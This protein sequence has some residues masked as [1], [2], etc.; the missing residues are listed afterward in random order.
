MLTIYPSG[1]KEILGSD[2]NCKVMRRIRFIFYVKKMTQSFYVEIFLLTIL[3]F[4]STNYVSLKNVMT[5][6]LSVKDFSSEKAFVIEAFQKTDLPLAVFLGILILFCV[7]AFQI[8][9]YIFRTSFRKKGWL[10]FL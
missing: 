4:L 5:N 8:F 10:S 9:L 3:L 7:L 1:H 2:F 6:F